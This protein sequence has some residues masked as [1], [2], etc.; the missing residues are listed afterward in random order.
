M[1]IVVADALKVVWALNF[2]FDSTVDAHKIKIASMV[3][4]HSRMSLLNIVDRSINAERL[5]EDQPQEL[6]P[7]PT[8]PV[9]GELPL[10]ILVETIWYPDDLNVS[11]EPG[12]PVD[13]HAE[14][15][16]DDFTVPRSAL[17]NNEGIHFTHR[18]HSK[19]FRPTV[20]LHCG[21]PQHPH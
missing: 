11:Y 16:I 4:E 6:A 3:D 15:R 14:D 13:R 5:I 21:L 19:A 17:T 20:R 2:Q 12:V 9:I 10:F 8:G 7:A 1:P 18:C